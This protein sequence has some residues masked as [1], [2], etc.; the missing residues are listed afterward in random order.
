MIRLSREHRAQLRAEAESAWPEECCG[1]IVGR[2]GP[3]G[4]EISSL[5]PTANVAGA[6]RHEH[7]EVDPAAHLR[8]QRK[9]RGTEEAV[10]GV[11]HS[12]PAGPAVPSAHDLARAIEPGWLWIIVGLADGRTGEI[13]GFV[14]RAGGFEPVALGTGD[15]T[16]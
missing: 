2:K 6:D 1:L 8:L 3:D 10:I 7:F 13:N 11:Y 15:L 5:V 4:T 14:H 12:H 9:L 16:L